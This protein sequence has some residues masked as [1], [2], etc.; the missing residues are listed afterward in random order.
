VTND[1]FIFQTPDKIVKLTPPHVAD[2]SGQ[3]RSPRIS[4]TPPDE[5]GLLVPRLDESG[6]ESATE[7]QVRTAVEHEVGHFG[8]PFFTVSN[9]RTRNCYI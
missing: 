1:E 6:T 8:S 4:C 2:G 3:G 7:E 5:A 9:K